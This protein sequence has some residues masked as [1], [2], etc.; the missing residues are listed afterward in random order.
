M[1]LGGGRRCHPC[2]L[3]GGRVSIPSAGRRVCSSPIPGNS[4]ASRLQCPGTCAAGR[5]ASPRCSPQAALSTGAGS[6]VSHPRALRV[7]GAAEPSGA[8][9]VCPGTPGFVGH[10]CTWVAVPAL[11]RVRTLVTPQPW[12]PAPHR[13]WAGDAF[14]CRPGDFANYRETDTKKR[15]T[16]NRS[17]IPQEPSLEI[18]RRGRVPGKGN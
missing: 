3:G 6:C 2:G 8:A 15:A 5:S 16:T 1:R 11:L 18:W 7:C 14:G 10:G 9:G 12:G 17:T 4:G 13:P